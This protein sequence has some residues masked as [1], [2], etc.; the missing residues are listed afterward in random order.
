MTSGPPVVRKKSIGQKY[1]CLSKIPKYLSRP[2]L[3]SFPEIILR[4]L[5][6]SSHFSSLCVPSS[7]HALNSSSKTWPCAT[8]SVSFSVQSG[9]DRS[10][11][12]LVKSPDV[13]RSFRINGFPAGPNFAQNGV[14]MLQRTEI[15]DWTEFL[16][17]TAVHTTFALAASL[18]GAGNWFHSAGVS[19]PCDRAP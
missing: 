19:R 17:T 1:L 7:G 8:R 9:N 3:Y 14:T 13:P 5:I 16:R 12:C 4:C 10:C 15:F 2:E 18:R 11:L 6:L